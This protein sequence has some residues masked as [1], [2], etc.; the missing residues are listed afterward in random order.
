MTVTTGEL[1]TASTPK[2]RPR[3]RGLLGDNVARTV[4]SLQRRLLL[5]TP[6]QEAVGALARL[7]RVAGRPPGSDILM[8]KYVGLSDQILEALAEPY[9]AEEATD[10]EHAKAAAVTLFAIHQQSQRVPMHVDGRGLGYAIGGLAR[11]SKHPEGVRRR[12]A[13]L[14]TAISFDE[15]LY[16]LRS[17]TFMLREHKIPLDYGLLADDLRTLRRPGG[18]PRMQSTWGREF[19]RS[20]PE[21]D[22]DIQSQTTEETAS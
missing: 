4:E 3:R 21:T 17:L 10:A 5:P 1:G 16:R 20:M 2:R 6:S 13:A 8:D 18:R 14:G 11:K 15:A 19:F 12:F 22:C 7:R 9:N